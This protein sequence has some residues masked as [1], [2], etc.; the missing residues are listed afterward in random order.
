MR[1]APCMCAPP[2]RPAGRRRSRPEAWHIT[3]TWMVVSSIQT[4]HVAGVVTAMQKGGTRGHGF[5]D[6]IVCADIARKMRYGQDM[7]TCL[8]KH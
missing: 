7:C 6:T 5:G 2:P 8:K 3:G 4:I 1:H